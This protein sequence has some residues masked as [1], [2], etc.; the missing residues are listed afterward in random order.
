[1]LR[2]W[3]FYSPAP[4]FIVLGATVLLVIP[5]L[6]VIALLGVVCL[7]VYG[8]VRGVVALSHAASRAVA[9]EPTAPA[10]ASARRPSV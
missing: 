1:M 9:H 8:L 7:M 2:S 5:Y 10:L 3:Y 6:A 4:V